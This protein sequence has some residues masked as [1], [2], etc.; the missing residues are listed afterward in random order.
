[1]ADGINHD[2]YDTQTTK[3]DD[4]IS[5]SKMINQSHHRGAGASIP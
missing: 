5:S 3:H 4:G 2:D 1:M